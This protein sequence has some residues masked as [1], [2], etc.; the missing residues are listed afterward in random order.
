MKIKA[1]MMS[2]QEEVKIVRLGERLAFVMSDR[3]RFSSLVADNWDEVQRLLDTGAAE[4]EI[5][6]AL[7]G[8]KK[9]S[10]NDTIFP[11]AVNESAALAPPRR[12]SSLV[13]DNWDQV[14]EMLQNGAT[15]EE[16]EASLGNRIP[17]NDGAAGRAST[18]GS[19][20]QTAPQRQVDLSFSGSNPKPT[21][22]A[23][24][25][26]AGR[27]TSN[28]TAEADGRQRFSSLVLDNWND[29]QVLL[30]HGKTA[31]EIEDFLAKQENKVGADGLAAQMLGQRQSEVS[32]GGKPSRNFPSTNVEAPTSPRAM[33]LGGPP[34][35]RGSQVAPSLV[36]GAGE[37]PLSRASQRASQ[38]AAAGRTTSPRGSQIRSQSQRPPSAI[39]NPNGS[40]TPRRRF[41]SLVV[42]HWDEVEAIFAKGGT[43]PE[44]EAYFQWL[45]QNGVN[46]S[47]AAVDTWWNTR[48]NTVGADAGA[49]G[50][51]ANTPQQAPPGALFGHVPKLLQRNIFGCAQ[52][53]ILGCHICGMGNKVMC[54]NVPQM[55]FPTSSPF[56][57]VP[58][59]VVGPN[60]IGYARSGLTRI[61]RGATDFVQ[62]ASREMADRHPEFLLEGQAT[63]PGG[64][65]VSTNQPMMGKLMPLEVPPREVN[66]PTYAV[67]TGPGPDGKIRRYLPAFPPMN[68]ASGHRG[69][70]EPAQNWLSARP[71]VS[72]KNSFVFYNAGLSAGAGNDF[73]GHGVMPTTDDAAGCGSLHPLMH[74]KP[75]GYA[76]M[77]GLHATAEDLAA[78]EAH[79]AMYRGGGI[80]GISSTGAGGGAGG[81]LDVGGNANANNGGALMMK[82]LSPR[83]AAAGGG[84]VT[85]P[86]QMRS[87]QNSPRTGGQDGFPLSAAQAAPAGSF[88]H[89]DHVAP[90]KPAVTRYDRNQVQDVGQQLQ[91]PKPVLARY[92]L[93]RKPNA[94]LSPERVHHAVTN[95]GA[96]MPTSTE[97]NTSAGPGLHAPPG[98]YAKDASGKWA[99]VRPAQAA[100]RGVY[101]PPAVDDDD[102]GGVADHAAGAAHQTR[103]SA[104]NAGAPGSAGTNYAPTEPEAAGDQEQE[105]PTVAEDGGAAGGPPDEA[106]AEG[107]HNHYAYLSSSNAGT[108]SLSGTLLSSNVPTIISG[109]P[110]KNIPEVVL[111]SYERAG[112]TVPHVAPRASM[113]KSVQLSRSGAAPP[114]T[115]TSFVCSPRDDSASR[116]AEN[117]K[118]VVPPPAFDIRGAKTVLTRKPAVPTAA[119]L[120]AR[121]RQMKGEGGPTVAVATPPAANKNKN[122]ERNKAET[123]ADAEQGGHLRGGTGTALIMPKR[124]VRVRSEA[125]DRKSV[126]RERVANLKEKLKQKTGSERKEI[127][128]KLVA[129]LGM[130]DFSLADLESQLLKV[131]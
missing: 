69:L 87:R 73:V 14:Q 105:Y 10:V 99:P 15:I 111:K 55:L 53:G 6:K 92:D 57:G 102:G 8:T 54:R 18:R 49:P 81:G 129:F 9:S 100:A 90:P 5:E 20:A 94:P 19:V 88:G 97:C 33:E 84:V 128:R 37:N 114:S 103:D 125:V 130:T 75:P 116:R 107:E 118:A 86:A 110:Q 32:E 79:Q 7:R 12:F 34:S 131:K 38:S 106:A 22:T 68:T 11:A 121:E 23:A 58:N 127:E 113:L 1:C 78:I 83:A 39:M 89:Q 104:A 2:P 66:S 80:L 74:D 101:R 82:P 124:P 60:A 71:D 4:E 123:G 96:M 41:S 46:G 43:L 64:K 65:S 50:G 42:E 93:G 108:T 122:I 109:A 51:R 16:I 61:A 3:R 27:T 17:N 29:V 21:T 52:H 115:T 30:A 126:L 117:K 47:L 67:T 63:G 48:A 24:S 72:A 31:E 85:T 95:P 77:M 98:G 28:P 120:R 40:S 91:S 76:R 44:S 62:L 70:F 119:E 45:E 26:A 59:A 35:A 112:A 25:A 13:V 36:L 56:L